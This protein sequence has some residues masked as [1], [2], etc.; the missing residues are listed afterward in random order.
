MS[1]V[2]Q[3]DYFAEVVGSDGG[4]S[5]AGFPADFTD[6]REKAVRLAEVVEKAQDRLLSRKSTVGSAAAVNL[7]TALA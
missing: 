6:G 3:I 5:D 2:P 7:P 4:R 1:Q